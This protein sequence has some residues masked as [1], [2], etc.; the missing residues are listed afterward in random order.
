MDPRTRNAIFQ[1]SSFAAAATIVRNS[2]LFTTFSIT[3]SLIRWRAIRTATTLAQSFVAPVI[4]YNQ[5]PYCEPKRKPPETS[6]RVVGTR[7]ITPTNV[8]I[9]YHH[10]AVSP[11]FSTKS[12]AASRP[13]LTSTLLPKYVYAKKETTH[14]PATIIVLLPDR[15][16]LS[17][18]CTLF[19]HCLLDPP[20]F[21]AGFGESALTR[22]CVGADIAQDNLAQR[23]VK[24][25]RLARAST[26]NR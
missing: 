9:I 2:L 8:N 3:I 6:M 1:G 23:L 14:T 12:T 17:C 26:H 4:G 19:A 20:S 24:L 16:P 5:R 22:V 13:A 25:S 7:Q 21:G 10:I 15:P 18:C 11:C